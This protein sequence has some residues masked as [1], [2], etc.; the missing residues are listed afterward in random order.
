MKPEVLLCGVCPL[1]M[2]GKLC[3]QVTEFV[4]AAAV[5]ADPMIDVPT[6]KP[7]S[8]VAKSLMDSYAV[9]VAAS[10]AGKTACAGLLGCDDID[11]QRPA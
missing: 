10:E 3:S 11:L 8:E 9:G 1:S 5:Q 7:R 4:I 6:A 2:G